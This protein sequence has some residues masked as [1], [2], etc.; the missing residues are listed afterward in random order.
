MDYIHG[1]KMPVWVTAVERYVR[2]EKLGL[3]RTFASEDPLKARE[4]VR[5]Q[6]YTPREAYYH[7]FLSKLWFFCAEKHLDTCD[8]EEHFF[9]CIELWLAEDPDFEN[10]YGLWE[11]TFEGIGLVFPSTRQVKPSMINTTIQSYAPM[12][13]PTGLLDS[14]DI[15]Y[16]TKWKV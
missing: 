12:P 10:Q 15:I 14:L 11:L 9:K 1:S 5:Q 13:M 7:P 16:G 2:L 4:R 8:E 6:A 3:A